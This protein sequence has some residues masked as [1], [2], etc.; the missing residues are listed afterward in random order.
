MGERQGQGQKMT[1][2]DGD[3]V[4]M[5]GDRDF[6]RVETGLFVGGDRA[7]DFGSFPF[8]FFFFATDVGD[9]VI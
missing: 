4:T 8:H 5:Y 9:Y 2:E 7:K 1:V 6:G 3:T